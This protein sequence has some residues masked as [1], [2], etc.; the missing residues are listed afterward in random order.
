MHNPDCVTDFN[1]GE[2]GPLGWKSSPQ[3]LRGRGSGEVERTPGG[4]VSFGREEGKL[5]F[6]INKVLAQLLASLLTAVSPGREL[7]DLP[8][9]QGFSFSLTPHRV[10][11]F[12]RRLKVIHEVRPAPHVA[13]AWMR[14]DGHY[15]L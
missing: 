8:K 5:N 4:W 9:F 12:V 14:E 10:K 3:L 6:P 11:V 15:C 13:L 2:E 1:C 7:N